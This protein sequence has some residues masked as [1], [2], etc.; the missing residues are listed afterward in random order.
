VTVKRQLKCLFASR[1]VSMHAHLRE[2]CA[3]LSRWAPKW[4]VPLFVSIL[5]WCYRQSFFVSAFEGRNSQWPATKTKSSLAINCQLITKL[6]CLR[7]SFHGSAP[8][9]DKQSDTE[10]R[11]SDK[12]SVGLYILNH[13]RVRTSCVLQS[14]S[15]DLAAF[16]VITSQ[17]NLH[18]PCW[19]F[20]FGWCEFR[21]G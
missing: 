16:T 1:Q 14:P 18:S 17:S 5:M 2:K 15:T 7:R 3:Q 13:A 12:K 21:P 4:E 20:F 6:L 8:I 11:L 10:T 19:I 9:A